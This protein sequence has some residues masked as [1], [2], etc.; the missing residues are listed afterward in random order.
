MIKPITSIMLD[1][2]EASS[3]IVAR[4]K[5]GDTGRKIRATLVEG[6]SVYRI[7]PGCTAV[8]AATKPD[9]KS[10]YNDCEIQANSI[11]YTVTEPTL[12][13]VG[14]MNCEIKLYDRNGVL[15]T[16]PTFTIQVWRPIFHGANLTESSA[17]YLAFAKIAGELQEGTH[18]LEAGDDLNLLL[19]NGVHYLVGDHATIKAL[20]DAAG[21]V[22][23]V[24]MNGT[25]TGLVPKAM[26]LK[27][28][29]GSSEAS[30]PA[31]PVGQP[32]QYLRVY[33]GTQEVSADAP[34]VSYHFEFDRVH[35]Y[36]GTEAD[37]SSWGAWRSANRNV[38][39]LEKD[40]AAAREI[41]VAEYGVTTAEEIMAE[42]EAG[43]IC[44]CARKG[45][46]PIL[47][48]SRRNDTGTGFV[49][50]GMVGDS[51][52]MY[53][54]TAQSGWSFTIDSYTKVVEV[55]NVDHDETI[56]TERAVWQ[57]I[58]EREKVLTN[59]MP[60]IANRVSTPSGYSFD[61]TYAEIN[62][63]V[64]AGRTIL[65]NSYNV[66][67]VHSDSGPNYYK[68]LPFVTANTDASKP[69]LKVTSADVW[70]EVETGVEVMTEEKVNK[71]IDEKLA[72]LT[73]V[74]EVGA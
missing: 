7:E 21:I 71:L 14:S 2:H 15:I 52:A 73:N 5:M 30:D 66:L 28:T 24:E 31:N 70:S 32:Y 64:A 33:Y 53:T 44:F 27:V 35:D 41:F 51:L 29:R 47:P 10:I 60:L 37:G 13:A 9:G 67:Y 12:A 36:V 59:V 8:F 18:L 62:E 39:E 56:P 16:S 57:K 63:A 4:F 1:I 20:L 6:G 46:V 22:H 43:K 26:F 11:I 65:L 58:S 42:L 48:Y 38:Y 69:G 61:K 49:F 19:E 45:Y 3:Q 25:M 34:G 17:E 68:F 74:A 23:P 40:L 55:R 54:L 72:A 50:A